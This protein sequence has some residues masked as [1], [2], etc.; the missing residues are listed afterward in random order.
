MASN[1]EQINTQNNLPTEI[2]LKSSITSNL[3]QRYRIELGGSNITPI[4]TNKVV[5][6]ESTI[7]QYLQEGSA[8]GFIA[9]SEGDKII[10]GAKFKIHPRI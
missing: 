5:A 8:L 1:L 4:T 9:Y 10:D 2:E 6:A 3:D 7:R